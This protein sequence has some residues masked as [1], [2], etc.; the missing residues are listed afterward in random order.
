MKHKV[1]ASCLKSDSKGRVLYRYEKPKVYIG[2][3]ID[4]ETMMLVEIISGP[5]IY[6]KPMFISNY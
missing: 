5:V 3:S 4:G 2:P 6:K 1:K